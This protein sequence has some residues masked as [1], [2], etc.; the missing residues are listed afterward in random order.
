MPGEEDG[1]DLV[2]ELLV[3]HPDAV[4]V[5]RAEEERD[6][7]ALRIIPARLRAPLVLDEAVDDLVE[8]RERAV[9]IAVRPDR[10]GVDGLLDPLRA[11]HERHELDDA[12]GERAR[13]DPG[14]HRPERR[15]EHLA[16]LARFGAEER[17]DHDLERE[18]DH[19]L[20]DVDRLAR[21]GRPRRPAVRE[22]ARVLEHHGRKLRQP[23]ALKCRLDELPLTRPR[24]AVVREE[25]A[26]GER[27]ETLVQ[28]LLRIVACVVDE[29]VAQARR[30]DE[31]EERLTSGV[32]PSDARMRLVDRVQRV[33]RVLPAAGEELQE[34][35]AR[36]AR[37]AGGGTAVGHCRRA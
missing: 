17:L 21:G 6:D 31:E 11:P 30:L 37:E 5:P 33:E 20:R 24:G 18:V 16:V 15:P 14:D 34:L 22:G 1:D 12:V 9:E 28:R 35:H 3:G 10:E 8:L 23:I 36:H 13:L 32:E 19:L 26:A 2:A 25:A 27:L 4:L 7:V 29:D